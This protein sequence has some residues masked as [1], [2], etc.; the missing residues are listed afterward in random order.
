MWPCNHLHRRLWLFV[1]PENLHFISFASTPHV[2]RISWREAAGDA[3][4]VSISL[5]A[6][7]RNRRPFRSVLRR[8]PRDRCRPHMFKLSVP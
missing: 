8:V 1:L 5:G 2:S 6:T 7:I 3:R 4:R